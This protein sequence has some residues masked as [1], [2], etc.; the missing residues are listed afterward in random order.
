MT[1]LIPLAIDI[2]LALSRRFLPIEK[3]TAIGSFEVSVEE[4]MKWHFI[5]VGLF[6]I[7]WPIGTALSYWLVSALVVWYFRRLPAIYVAPIDNLYWLLPTLI[8]GMLFG[9]LLATLIS[10][11]ML[12][13]RY[14][15]FSANYDQTLGFDNQKAGNIIIVGALFLVSIMMFVGFT[16]YTRFT[17][18]GIHTRHPY[19]LQ[20][21]FHPYS[22]VAAVRQLI[23]TD[24]PREDHVFVI[25]YTDG[26]YWRAAPVERG[27]IPG[28]YLSI[29]A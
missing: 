29:M 6:S 10:K 15:T 9:A 7:G 14:E 27:R 13:S 11:G 19:L 1:L 16:S 5:G 22:E 21:E 25:E 3:P 4:N 8:T 24:R 17:E 26:T 23:R 20:E 18:E 28:N 2:L 12:K